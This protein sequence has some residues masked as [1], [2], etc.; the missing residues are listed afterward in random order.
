N[1]TTTT[2]NTGFFD[3]LSVFPTPTLST[4]NAPVNLGPIINSS[5]SDTQDPAISG[6]GL[7]LYFS[8]N[9]PGRLSGGNDLWVSRRASLNDPWGAPQDLGPVINDPSSMENRAPNLS[10]DQHWLFFSS[11][12]AGGY[13]GADIWAS[14]RLN[15]QDDLGWQPPIN[16]GSGVN[17]PYDE[18]S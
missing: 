12:R 16:L 4:W 1:P 18:S 13:G 11:D 9:R 10:P 15:T 5:G 3:D 14:Y 17:T 7:S 6:D 8:S 2:A